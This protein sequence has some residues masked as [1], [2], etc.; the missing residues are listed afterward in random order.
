VVE[1]YRE[2]TLENTIKLLIRCKMAYTSRAMLIQIFH[3]IAE[4]RAAVDQIKSLIEAQ[5]SYK[6]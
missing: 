1:E 2:V 5:T 4:Y 6:V 3:M